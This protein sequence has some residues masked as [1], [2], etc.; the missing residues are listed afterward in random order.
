MH[1]TTEELLASHIGPKFV[2]YACRIDQLAF[3]LLKH[4]Q[5][6]TEARVASAIRGSGDNHIGLQ[7]KIPVYISYFTLRVNDDGSIS[8]FGDLYGHDVRM[9]AALNRGNGALDAQTKGNEVATSQRKPSAKRIRQSGALT[10]N[11]ARTGFGF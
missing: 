5:G 9:A 6:W 1:D 10:N 11:L 3:V 7:Q 4:D 8:T 2:L